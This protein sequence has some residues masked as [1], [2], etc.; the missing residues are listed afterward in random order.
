MNYNVVMGNRVPYVWDYDIDEDQFRGLL[1]GNLVIGRLDR[2]WAAVRLIEYGTYEE[3][4]R[5]LGF[6]K[7]VE[8]WAEWRPYVKSEGRRRGLD[9]LVD[10]IPRQHPELL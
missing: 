8:G 3:L 4:V 7:I 1:N 9:F 2:C 6:R 10:W 5:E